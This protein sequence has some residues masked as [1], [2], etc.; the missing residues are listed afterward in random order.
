V[1]GVHAF[2]QPIVE[3]GQSASEVSNLLSRVGALFGQRIPLSSPRPP[4]EFCTNG[5][6]L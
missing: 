1:A 5:R 3:H 6:H 4:A 2:T